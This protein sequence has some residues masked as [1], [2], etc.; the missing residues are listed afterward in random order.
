ML[1][2]LNKEN[3]AMSMD[4]F[5]I[6]SE[7]F[8]KIRDYIQ[9]NQESSKPVVDHHTPRELK[10]K[11]NTEIPQKGVSEDEF[12]Q[13]VDTY[14]NYSVRTGHKQ[15]LNQLYSGFNFPAFMGD[16]FTALTTTSMVT[17]EV[18]PMGTYIEMEM[19]N[20]MKSYAGYDKNNS[21]GVFLTGGSNANLIAMFSARNRFFPEGR[22][23]GYDRNKRLVAFVNKQAHYSFD[24]AANVLGIGSDNVI[25]VNCDDKGRMLPSELDKEIKKCIADGGTPFFIGATCGTTMLAAFDPIEEIYPIAKKYDVWFHADGSFG[26]SLL[27]SEKYRGIMKGLEKTDSFCW[28]PHKLMNIPLTCSALLVRERGVLHKNLTDINTDYLYHNSEEI[29]DLG[30]KSI[31]CGRRADAVKLW[32]AWKYFGIEGY[33]ARVNNQVEMAMYV[34]EIVKKT[35]QIELIAERQSVAVNFRYVPNNPTDLNSFNMELRDI[36]RTKGLSIINYGY[37]FDHILAIRFNTSNGEITKD[38]VDT[39][40]SYFLAEAEKLENKLSL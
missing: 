6:L 1:H 33:E 23:K 2:A 5:K 15:F 24:T 8:G 20:L 36:L 31:Q 14:L 10:E 13:L 25:H 32:F 18:A 21:D 26:G 22:F 3:S 39:F 19:I 37:I 30:L 34:E 29:E 17:Y 4:N 35:P 11:I 9:E 12:L 27:L 40:F 28:N 16:V 38:D 7:S